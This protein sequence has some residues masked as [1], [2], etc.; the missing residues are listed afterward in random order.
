MHRPGVT[1]RCARQTQNRLLYWKYASMRSSAGRERDLHGRQR[2]QHADQPTDTVIGKPIEKMFICCATRAMIPNTMFT[3]SSMAIIGNAIHRPSRKTSAPQ[4]GAGPSAEMQRIGSDGKGIE[5]LND[6]GDQCQV[7]ARGNEQPADKDPEETAGR[8]RFAAV[9]GLKNPE[10]SVP[11]AVRRFHRQFHR[12]ED[13]TH[14]KS[15]ETPISSLLEQPPSGRACCPGRSRA[16]RA[17]WPVHR[18][19]STGPD[20]CA[21]GWGRCPVR[22]RASH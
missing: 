1:L 20:R 22:T 15:R 14:G 11:S 10:S 2:Q 9:I 21:R 19:R 5:A 4:P 7:S 12:A 17:A 13:N 8:R 16:M 18:V 3:N 6:R